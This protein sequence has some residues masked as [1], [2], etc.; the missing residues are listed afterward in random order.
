MMQDRG[1]ISGGSQ[2]SYEWFRLTISLSLSVDTENKQCI[3]R[4]K[5]NSETEIKIQMKTCTQRNSLYKTDSL[6]TSTTLLAGVG[7]DVEY[8]YGIFG[9]YLAHR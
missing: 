5:K 9:V 2:I 8:A 4:T 6:K 3:W 1:D 7:W